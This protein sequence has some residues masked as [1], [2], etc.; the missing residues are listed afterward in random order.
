[1]AIVTMGAL[2]ACSQTVTGEGG[3]VTTR[4]QSV[5]VSDTPDAA[6]P[7]YLDELKEFVP[8]LATMRTWDPCAMHD[9][10]AAET[11]TGGSRSFIVPLGE[12]NRC[13]L[14]LAGGNGV[15]GDWSLN[16]ELLLETILDS[17][18][19]SGTLDGARVF[20]Q[21]PPEPDAPTFGISCAFFLPLDEPVGAKLDVTTVDES[22]PRDTVCEIAEKYFTTLLPKWQN[23]PLAADGAS[24][25][26]I[27]L[28]GKDPC[29]A[30]APAVE[31]EPTDQAGEQRYL[32]AL[33]PYACQLTSEQTFT[34]IE[35]SYESLLDEGG[36]SVDLAGTKAFVRESGGGCEYK[37]PID[38]E[39]KFRVDDP[40]LAG[41]EPGLVISLDTCD[42]ALA[43]EIATAAL[44]QPEPRGNGSRTAEPITL[45]RL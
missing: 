18:Y 36:Q 11:A 17:S 31:A 1:M 43:A 39:I 13:T 2:A 33:N 9:I 23:P 41:V 12:L 7:P 26:R 21:L 14:T 3:A 42:T 45:G 20:R 19:E 16:V 10:T 6:E 35:V 8:A 5:P 34:P 27:S 37:A 29:A 38:P 44:D 40:S 32:L 15:K 4:A 22:V 28:Y 24:T 25:P 30:L